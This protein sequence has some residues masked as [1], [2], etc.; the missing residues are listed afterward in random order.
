MGNPLVLGKDKLVVP[1]ALQYRHFAFVGTSGYG[2]S[3][4]IEE[5]LMHARRHHHK[6]LVVDVAGAFVAKFGRPGDRILSL[7]DARSAAWDFWSEPLATPENIA[8]ALIEADVTQNQYFWKSARQVLAAMLRSNSSLAGFIEDLGK[9]QK[10]LK[11]KLQKAGELATKMMGESGGDQADGVI[12]T[13]MLDLAFVKDL[14]ANNVG[15]EAFSITK[16]MNDPAERGFVFLVVDEPGLET[17][18]PLIRTWFEMAALAA[19]S[20]HPY[21]HRCPHTW[22]VIDEAKSVGQ[23][24]SLPAILDKGRKYNVS[25]VLGFQAFSHMKRI[26]GE[27]D[28]SSIFQGMQNQFFFR[29]SEPESAEYA[30]DALGEQDVE[31]ASYGLSFGS[32]ESSER[33]NVNHAR[34]RRQVVLASELQSQ[35]ILKAYVKLCHHQPVA[36]TFAPTQLMATCEPFVPNGARPKAIPD[37]EGFGVFSEEGEG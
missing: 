8:A 14:Q 11:D 9:S 33:G 18:K 29:M 31:Q 28:A 30:S 15:R 20:R 6:A 37:P 4:A 1:E 32:K 12:G 35:D 21:D 25:V 3:T 36:M 5:I 7:R 16:W 24:P 10:E 34:T 2:K 17:S 13:T 23:L 19:L 22:L 27:Y 26:Y